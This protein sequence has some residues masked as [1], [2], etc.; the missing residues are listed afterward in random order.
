LTFAVIFLTSLLTIIVNK[1][2][3]VYREKRRSETMS[4]IPYSE[5]SIEAIWELVSLCI[6]LDHGHYEHKE[7]TL[8]FFS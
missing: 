4:T 3:P 1:I 5:P 7:D 8:I 2:I 6:A